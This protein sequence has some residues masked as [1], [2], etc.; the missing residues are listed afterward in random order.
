MKATC[1]CCKEQISLTK[2]GTFVYHK[3]F[4]KGRRP[5]CSGVGNFPKAT[6]PAQEDDRN[7]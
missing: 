4:I 5:P 6:M 1:P 3:W 2:K 7:G